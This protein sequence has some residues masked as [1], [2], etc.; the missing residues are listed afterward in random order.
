VLCLLRTT[1]HITAEP[2]VLWL[3]QHL[4]PTPGADRS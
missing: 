1:T 2:S 4:G 3:R